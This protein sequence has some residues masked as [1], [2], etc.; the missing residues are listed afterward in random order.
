MLSGEKQKFVNK[1][2]KKAGKAIEKYKLITPEDLIIVAISGGIDSLVML[3]ILA[4]RKKYIPHNYSLIALHVDIPEIPKYSKTNE[5][6]AF[7]NEVDVSLKTVSINKAEIIPRNNKSRCFVCAWH[8]RKAI[9][10]EMSQLKAGK[11]AF[12]HHLDDTIETLFMNMVNHGEFSAIPP[13]LSI[14]KGGFK[15]IRPLILLTKPEIEKYAYIQ[16]IKELEG[17]CPYENSNKREKYKDL[18]KMTESLN[19]KAKLNI[20]KSMHNINNKH[21]PQ[22]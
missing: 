16:D 7:C 19:K 9:F 17:K 21:L 14:E 10:K 3:E 12:G 1:I 22:S 6:E 2:R 4:N 8:R 13:K 20:Y 5:I 18:I 15:I 11:L